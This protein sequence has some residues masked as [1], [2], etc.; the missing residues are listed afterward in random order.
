MKNKIRN[1]IYKL[2]RKVI[3]KRLIHGHRLTPYYLTH[4]GWI[5]KDGC[6]IEPIVK[7][8]DRVSIEFEYHYYRVRHSADKT[9]IALESTVEWLEMYMLLLDKHRNLNDLIQS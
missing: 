5:K 3:F 9:F 7:D 8:R 2:A 6:Y 1:F 4:R